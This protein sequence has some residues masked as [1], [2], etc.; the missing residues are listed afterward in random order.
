MNSN[1]KKVGILLI[2]LAVLVGGYALYQGVDGAQGIGLPDVGTL[3]EADVDVGEVTEP[4]AVPALGVE[5]ATL[6]IPKIGTETH[7]QYVGVTDDGLMD[8]PSNFS[9]VAWYKLGVKPGAVG[10]A[11]IAGH[12]S[13]AGNKWAVFI[14][15]EKLGIGDGVY[16]EGKDGETLHFRVI[17]KK[18][19]PYDLQGQEL[20][21]IF[22][23]SGGRYLNLITC[24]GSWVEEI[25]TN[26]TRLVVFTELVE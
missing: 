15:L 12:Q 18:M 8:V 25:G 13:R 19:Y 2:T 3:K 26:D 4:K 1:G 14:E 6:L 7:V 24:A 17:E 16:V 20:E 23:A 5:P 9:D 10:S 21:R 11:V 22:T